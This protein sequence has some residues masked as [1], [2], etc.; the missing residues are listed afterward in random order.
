MRNVMAGKSIPEPIIPNTSR[1]QDMDWALE[2]FI[3][4]E[5]SDVIPSL[6]FSLN[7]TGKERSKS[8]WQTWLQSGK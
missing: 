1:H 8:F 5:K 7:T 4:T 2:R 6:L 3:A